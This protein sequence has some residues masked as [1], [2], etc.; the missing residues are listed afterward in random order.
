[1]LK[2]LNETI[3]KTLG[4]IMRE[5]PRCM[6]IFKLASLADEYGTLY[7]LSDSKEDFFDLCK[8][9]Q[10]SNASRDGYY[11]STSGSYNAIDGVLYVQREVK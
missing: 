3:P 7:A 10:E 11:Y 4:T 9:S 2:I 1:M 8:L 5:Y 6:F